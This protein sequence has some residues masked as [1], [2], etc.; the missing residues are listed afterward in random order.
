MDLATRYMG[1]RPAQPAGRVGLAALADRRRR[2]AAR[3]RRRRRGR[4]LLAVRGA[5]PPRGRR[6]RARSPTPA[7]RAS[8]SRSPTSRT[9]PKRTPARAR[10]LSL[11][12]RAAAAVDIPVIGSLNG[13]TPTG[14][15]DYARAMQDVGAAAIE[16]NIYYLPGDATISGRDVEQRHVDILGRVKEAVTVPVAVKL[17]PFFSS[18]GELARTARRGGRRRAGALQPVP[19]TRHRRRDARRGAAGGALQPGRGAAA[20]HV[21]RAPPRTGSRLA[22]RDHRC[23][24]LGRRG[25]VPARRRRRR[26]DRLGAAAP[27]SRIRD[28]ASRRALGLDGAQGV[29]HGRRAARA[30]RGAGRLRRVGLRAGGIRRR[31][32]RR[33]TPAS[34]SRKATTT[35]RAHAAARSSS[36]GG[37]PSARAR[38]RETAPPRPR[39]GPC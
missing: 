35:S 27:R 20:A 1:L 11:L 3:R 5:D 6:E 16:L 12:A 31:A 36:P 28:R 21:D 18:T 7:P 10:Y 25:Q 23:R 37:P 19:A 13:V 32:A 39:T 24:E 4:P 29:R 22:R 14:W 30:T 33:R 2:A 17:S 9:P 26:D 34:T 38:R 8:P 15:V